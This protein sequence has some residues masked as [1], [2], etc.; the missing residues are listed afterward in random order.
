MR[1]H[2]W[3]IVLAGGEGTRMRSYIAS[4]LGVLRPKQYC[5]FTGTRSLLQHA[6]DRMSR[7]VDHDQVITVIGRGHWSH[8]LE[9]SS[10]RLPGRIIEQP[11]SRGTG[12][13]VF[14]ALACIM[15]VDPEAVLLVAPSDHFVYPETDF[16][17]QLEC[18]LRVADGFPD[19][20]VLL[21]A[22]GERQGTDFGWIEPGVS[23]GTGVR[24][25]RSFKEKPSAPQ[26][27]R[28][29][30][31]GFLLNTMLL[32]TKARALWSVGKAVLPA[33]TRPF[34]SLLDSLRAAYRGDLARGSAGGMSWHELYADLP[35]VDLSRDL[36]EHAT[37]QTLVL[38]MNPKLRWS[39]WGR[40]ERVRESLLQLRTQESLPEEA[41]A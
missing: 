12:A 23:L 5:V 14:L 8:L 15:A 10:G 33:F 16:I 4:R 28:F 19:H 18:M 6:L 7:A 40:P 29:L 36:L 37:R 31:R 39:D 11:D 25:V 27:E 22:K 2:S 34:G 9:T 17:N 35:S 32:A 24:S 38:E 20:L 21:G 13:A 41:W 3:A 1:R 26:A 30:D